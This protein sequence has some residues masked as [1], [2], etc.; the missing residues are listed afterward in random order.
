MEESAAVEMTCM[1]AL[2]HG[3]KHGKRDHD[4]E[5]PPGQLA[6]VR[7]HTVIAAGIVFLF[8]FGVLLAFAWLGWLAW[9]IASEILR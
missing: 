9:E 4:L 8:L 1:K 5:G 2:G 7:Y 3:E 6:V